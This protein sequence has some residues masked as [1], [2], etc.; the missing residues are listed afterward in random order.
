MTRIT[1]EIVMVLVGTGAVGSGALVTPDDD[2]Q[3]IFRAAAERQVG[4]Q[5]SVYRSRLFHFLPIYTGGTANRSIVKASVNV[6]TALPRGGFGS[7]GR[8]FAAGS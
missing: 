7:I 3:T 4:A 2:T 5:G 8:G 1:K 6:A